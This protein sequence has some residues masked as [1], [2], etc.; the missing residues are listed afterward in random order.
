MERKRN[1]RIADYI[2]NFKNNIKNKAIQANYC[3][4]EKIEN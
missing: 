1:R 3:E 4:K 2:R